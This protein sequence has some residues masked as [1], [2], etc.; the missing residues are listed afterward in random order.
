MPKK[1]KPLMNRSFGK[2][3]PDILIIS[4][5]T[6]TALRK[7]SGGLFLAVLCEDCA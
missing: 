7:Q 1:T 3:K 2:D 4:W 6:V 5:R